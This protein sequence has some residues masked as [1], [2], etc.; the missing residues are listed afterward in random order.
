MITAAPYPWQEFQWAHLMGLWHGKRLPHALLFTGIAGMGKYAMAQRLQ[1]HI[2]CQA[3]EPPCGICS[4]CHWLQQDYHPDAFYLAPEEEGKA[5]KVGGIRQWME[6]FQQSAHEKGGYR[7]TIIHPAHALNTAAANSLLKTLEEP[8][9]K[10]VIILVTESSSGLPA[11]IRS[12]CQVVNFRVERPSVAETWLNQQ[13]NEPTEGLLSLAEGAPLRALSYAQEKEIAFR[14]SLV[15]GLLAVQTGEQSPV[16]LGEEWHQL[17]QKRL[18]E[19]L[20]PIICDVIRL[21]GS[22][23]S[24]I[25]H[26][27]CHQLLQILSQRISWEHLFRLRDGLLEKSHWRSQITGINHQLLWESFLIEWGQE[28][29]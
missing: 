8:P 3:S 25:N 26:P 19:A 13:I 10:R 27:M 14:Q 28:G 1:A 12:R 9:E 4:S 6:Q 23:D 17:S 24:R 5:I 29:I 16:L 18:T 15:K 11:T 7:I 21:K 20:Q 22:S 2:L